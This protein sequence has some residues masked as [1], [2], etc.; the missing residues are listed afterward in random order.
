MKTATHLLLV[1]LLV[2]LVQA[3]EVQDLL[4][5]WKDMDILKNIANGDKALYNDA[6]FQK[7]AGETLDRIRRVVTNMSP[8]ER[9]KMRL[10]VAKHIG[11]QG[12]QRI[13]AFSKMLK[14]LKPDFRT[15][16]SS[17]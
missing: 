4:K 17:V 5:S 8:D 10:T 13:L 2:A 12:A 14:R 7:E 9:Q 1:T 11:P 3:G 15:Q 6:A 16:M